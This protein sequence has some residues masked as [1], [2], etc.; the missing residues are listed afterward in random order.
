MICGCFSHTSPSIETPAN[1]PAFVSTKDPQSGL[2]DLINP[3]VGHGEGRLHDATV[4]KRRIRWLYWPTVSGRTIM[5]LV[6][7]LIYSPSP[8]CHLHQLTSVIAGWRL[9]GWSSRKCV[10]VPMCVVMA[11]WLDDSITIRTASRLF[12]LSHTLMRLQRQKQTVYVCR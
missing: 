11:A 12:C 1:C 6:I 5:G 7:G 3:G 4:S 2:D 9:S 10:Y 8:E